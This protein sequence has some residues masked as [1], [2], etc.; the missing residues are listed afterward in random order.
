MAR[1]GE[2]QA[3]CAVPGGL[4]GRGPLAFTWSSARPLSER[5]EDMSCSDRQRAEGFLR[6]CCRGCG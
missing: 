2:G 1:P 3:C 5:S 6:L 4:K